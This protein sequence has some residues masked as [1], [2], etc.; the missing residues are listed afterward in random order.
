MRFVNTVAIV[1]Q[2][3]TCQINDLTSMSIDYAKLCAFGHWKS[4]AVACGDFR[5]RWLFRRLK[6]L[7]RCL[8]GWIVERWNSHG[9]MGSC[10]QRYYYSRLV[11]P[12]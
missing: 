7:G 2:D 9:G 1:V 11:S 12:S 3:P 10:L 6:C 4:V 8:M 5:R